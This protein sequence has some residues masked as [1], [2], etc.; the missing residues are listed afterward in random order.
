MTVRG[1]WNLPFYHFR[2]FIIR[3]NPPLVRFERGYS[4]CHTPSGTTYMT[5][6]D[7]LLAGVKSVNNFPFD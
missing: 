4:P 5:P 6:A 2:C 7:F 3:D 1:R